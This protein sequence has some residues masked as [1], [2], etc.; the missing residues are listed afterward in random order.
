EVIASGSDAETKNHVRIAKLV[1]ERAKRLVEE[2][3][4]ALILLDSLTQLCRAFNAVGPEGY[5]VIDG[6]ISTTALSEARAY[7]AE[8]RNFD[9]AGSLT[10]LATLVSGNG[11]PADELIARELRR[12]ANLEVVLSRDL[13]ARR[14][15]P[16]VDIA[17]STSSQS[18]LFLSAEAIEMMAWLR[19]K[20][21]RKTPADAM[22]FVLDTLRAYESNED[23]ILRVE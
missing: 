6:S 4:D 2:G 13:A 18:D 17:A 9:D 22:G 12:A 10:I 23:L 3:K 20:T 1:L 15:W 11:N 16:A 19:S 21:E 8:A 14:V 7:L 5:R